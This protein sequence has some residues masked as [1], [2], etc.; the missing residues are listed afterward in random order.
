[1]A[2]RLHPGVTAAYNLKSNDGGVQVVDV[3]ERTLVRSLSDRMYDL[4]LGQFMDGSRASGEPLNIDALAREFKVSQ[5]P[6]REALAKLESTGLVRR[7][8]LK[9]YRV[10]P[11]LDP[12]E[13]GKL[14]DARLAIEPAL[15]FETARRTTPEFLADLDVSVRDLERSVEL[16]DRE[17][18]SFKLYWA[19]DGRFH[20]LIAE[21]CSNPF[22][23]TAYKSLVGH[24][25]RFR[26]F[27][28]VGSESGAHF[29]AIEHRGIYQAVAD[30]QA[31]HAADL[32]R[33]H[34]AN[35]KNRALHS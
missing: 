20:S 22:L 5:T 28:K 12:I 18:E 23:E 21:Q 24:I 35:A 27:S 19:S 33:T 1:M 16:A 30:G 9:G 29:A 13:V 34:L 3:G 25:Q 10:A 26:L 11:S 15:A 4:L 32:M 17:S 14:L 6:L 2:S 8:A 31:D 7:E